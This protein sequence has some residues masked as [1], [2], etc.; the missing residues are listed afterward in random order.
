MFRCVASCCVQA[1]CRITS[2][3]E[4]LN[5]F[6]FIFYPSSEYNCFLI[7]F[8]SVDYQSHLSFTFSIFFL[9]FLSFAVCDTL[10]GSKNPDYVDDQPQLV[11]CHLFWFLSIGF[12]PFL[13]RT[14][15][16]WYVVRQ[17]ESRLRWDGPRYASTC[18]RRRYPNFICVV[19][20]FM[21]LLVFYMWFY[22]FLF[23]SHNK[24]SKKKCKTNRFG[25]WSW[26][27][28]VCSARALFADDLE[29]RPPHRPVVWRN[30]SPRR[31]GGKKATIDGQLTCVREGRKMTKMK[32]KE[33]SW[34]SESRN[35]KKKKQQK[36]MRFEEIVL[37]EWGKRNMLSHILTILFFPF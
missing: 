18:A 26:E 32:R 9:L 35:Q 19:F 17:Q 7:F 12:S 34:R 14:P 10:Y 2:N 20:F 36:Q 37:L 28:Q 5:Q 8:S 3:S 25:G 23:F 31:R 33:Q 15:Q 1:E 24:T 27:V 11:F 30:R 6:S 16:W 22:T 21:C 4:S 13:L 29:Q